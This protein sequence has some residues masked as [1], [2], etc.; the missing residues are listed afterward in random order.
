MPE[1]T[2]HYIWVGPPTKY[3]PRAISGHDVAGPIKMAKKLDE[4]TQEGGHR[5]LIKF[6]CLAEHQAF[7]EAEFAHHEVK[8]EVRTIESLLESQAQNSDIAAFISYLNQQLDALKK[9]D[10]AVAQRVFFKDKFSFLVLAEDS[11]GYVLDTN[12]FPEL[13][14]KVLLQ[15]E[16]RV[17]AVKEEN[18]S[19]FDFY[20]MYSPE[21]RHAK[22]LEPMKEFKA[23][24]FDGFKCFEKPCLDCRK[25]G[26]R[27]YY[28]KSYHDSCGLVPSGLFYFLDDPPEVL[29]ENLPYGD[30]NLQISNPWH[31]F[32]LENF[33]LYCIS[34][35]ESI[36]HEAMLK[37]P[38]SSNEGYVI[39][40]DGIYYVNKAKQYTG[41]CDSGISAY[42]SDFS[43]ASLNSLLLACPRRAV[44]FLV[45]FPKQHN[46]QFPTTP[47]YI[48]Y[49]VNTGGCTLL[50]HAVLLNKPKKHIDMLLE[51]GAS[52]DLA[53]K[54]RHITG[55][56][57]EEEIEELT[58][59][60]LAI[61]LD[62][63]EISEIF[64]K[65]RK[66]QPSERKIGSS[67]EFFPPA[68]A[69]ALLGPQPSADF[70]HDQWGQS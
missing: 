3:D 36:S 2:I 19:P 34:W 17:T 53:A 58:P 16:S 8:I 23:N 37:L 51:N 29:I 45:N 15:G 21:P 63:K 48:E 42:W 13:E 62:R 25:E 44:D 49:M 18:G 66:S 22:V 41:F 32:L 33:S 69:A 68:Q 67:V 30:I 5:N 1:T 61:R 43:E 31:L 4:Q 10:A 50:H 28:Y 7:Y 54:Y 12:V 46:K 35:G 6:W 27:K 26:I 65:W 52:L 38:F 55:I 24:A 39:S 47:F 14:K 60:E 40:W 20:F 59:K 11:G 57:S 64:A 70:R 9:P 56:A